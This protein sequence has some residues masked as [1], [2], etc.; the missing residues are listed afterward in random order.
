MKI[1]RRSFFSLFLNNLNEYFQQSGITGIEIEY[2]D[3]QML[4]SR[5]LLFAG[6]TVL[7][8]TTPEQL[9][10]RLSDFNT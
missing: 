5:V 9:Q 4:H 7:F 2:N 10:Q 6:D 1:F 3:A 8:A